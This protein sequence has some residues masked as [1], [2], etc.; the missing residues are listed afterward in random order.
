MKPSQ[1][2]SSW[3]T[4]SSSYINPKQK[5]L[6]SALSKAETPTVSHTTSIKQVPKIQFEAETTVTHH[7]TRK[8]Q[9]VAETPVFFSSCSLESCNTSSIHYRCC[10]QTSKI[11]EWQTVHI[12]IIPS[13]I[14]AEV[15]TLSTFQGD[16]IWPIY[17][18]LKI[19][20]GHNRW[21]CYSQILALWNLSTHSEW[22]FSV[23]ESW[24]QTGIRW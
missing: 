14:L 1:S 11:E 4:S 22:G 23:E 8:S 5:H 10:K 13:T 17:I 16:S 20:Q 21:S 24:R 12:G 2:S 19:S 9:S 15:Q 6:L 3:P 18:A 7:R